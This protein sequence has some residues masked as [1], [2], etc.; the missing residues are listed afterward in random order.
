MIARWDSGQGAAEIVPFPK[1]ALIRL[2]DLVGSVGGGGSNEGG[3]QS[4]WRYSITASPIGEVG[5]FVVYTE[6]LLLQT[7]SV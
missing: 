7:K 6:N 5:L 2:W 1:S 4:K 3:C